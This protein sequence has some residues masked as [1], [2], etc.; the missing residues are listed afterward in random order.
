MPKPDHEL[1]ECHPTVNTEA[2]HYLRNRRIEI[3][4]AIEHFKDDRVIFCDGSSAAFDTVIACTGYRMSFPFFERDFIDFK[5]NTPPLYL[6]MFHPLHRDLLFIGLFQPSG[7][8]WPL[9]D[10]QAK[11]AANYLIGNYKL[12]H[13]IDRRVLG[14]A[15]TIR[16]SFVQSPRHSVEVNY[17]EFRRLLLR[18][19]PPSAPV[20]SE[21]SFTEA[22]VQSNA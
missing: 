19:I 13:D 16:R 3:F 12:P 11:L 5:D 1:L 18:Q 22:A 4:P 20:W 7:S 21:A 9:S 6:R 8:I 14:E 15:E 2:L 10:L 17:H